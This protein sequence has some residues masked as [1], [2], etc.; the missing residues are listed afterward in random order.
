[1]IFDVV[2]WAFCPFDTPCLLARWLIGSIGQTSMVHVL[3]L[4]SVHMAFDYLAFYLSRLL[5][6]M[7][8]LGGGCLVLTLG[9]G[10]PDAALLG[11]EA[12]LD[13]LVDVFFLAKVALEVEVPHVLANVW[14]MDA[15]WM[16]M[17]VSCVEEMLVAELGWIESVS[18]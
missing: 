18:M 14:L 12:V 7:T 11:D 8:A 1:M 9:L 10:L 5:V 13:H 4:G 15:L 6:V 2:H 17:L 16:S 3:A